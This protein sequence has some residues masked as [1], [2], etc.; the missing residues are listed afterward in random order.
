MTR[1]GWALCRK[2]ALPTRS[3]SASARSIALA[4]YLARGKFDVVIEATGVPAVVQQALDVLRKRG[5][6]VIAGIH[7]RPV[8]VNLTRLVRDHQQIR[9][10]YRAPIAIWAR[11]L[12]FLS[13]NR[14][15]VH[16]TISHAM[17]LAQALDGFELARNKAASK[18]FIVP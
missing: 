5:I 13:R 14:E 15:L 6:L 11:V 3:T 17:P 9:G 1:C 4:P 8:S 16:H 2:W 18:V 12:D 7:A 10:T